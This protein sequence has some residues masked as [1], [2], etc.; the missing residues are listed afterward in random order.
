MPDEVEDAIEENAQQPRRV[1][2]DE[3]EVEQ[4]PLADQIA[5]DR[6][7]SSKAAVADQ[8]RG[9]RWNILKH[10]GGA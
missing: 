10:P 7:L 6:F 8:H 5:A 1:R 2:G 3:G 9:L 4:H